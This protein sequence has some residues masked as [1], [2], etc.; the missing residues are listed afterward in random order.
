MKS[1]II[2]LI[3]KTV[4]GATIV[5]CNGLLNK[6]IEVKKEKHNAMICLKI[7]ITRINTKGH[8]SLLCQTQHIPEFSKLVL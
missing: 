4:P 7:E 5:F 1:E 6:K 8:L 2:A 3:I